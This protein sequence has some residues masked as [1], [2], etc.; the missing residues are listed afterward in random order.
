MY[1]RD[2]SSQDPFSVLKISATK[3][4]AI[5]WEIFHSSGRVTFAPA[6][7]RKWKAGY[8]VSNTSRCVYWGA[9]CVAV[10]INLF[11]AA[12]V[13]SH[14]HSMCYSDSLSCL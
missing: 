12:R 2:Y 10:V 14:V 3:D 8:G 7:I 9:F 5:P 11:L 6:P 13:P 1:A 4:T